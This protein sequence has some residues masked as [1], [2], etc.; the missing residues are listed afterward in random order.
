[1]IRKNTEDRIQKTE[2]RKDIIFMI[3]LDISDRSVTINVPRYGD[4]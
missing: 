2:V 1:M 3:V 4:M